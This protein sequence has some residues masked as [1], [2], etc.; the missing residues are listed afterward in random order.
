MPVKKHMEQ[1]PLS[2]R[3]K[4]KDRV[5]VESVLYSIQEPCCTSEKGL[6]LTGWVDGFASARARNGED[7][8]LTRMCRGASSSPPC[9]RHFRQLTTIVVKIRK[10]TSP[11]TPCGFLRRSYEQKNN[12]SNKELS[13]NRVLLTGIGGFKVIT[14]GSFEHEFK[15]D[16]RKMLRLTWHVVLTDD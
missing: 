3:V 12:G 4:H 8:I 5:S 2:L 1:P 13:K 11:L 14:I 10:S 7:S 6:S 16:D 15:I 9:L